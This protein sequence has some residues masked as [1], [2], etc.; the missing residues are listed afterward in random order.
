LKK[1]LEAGSEN[2][3]ILAIVVSYSIKEIIGKYKKRSLIV[4]NKKSEVIF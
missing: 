4:I 3:S 2:I 1:I